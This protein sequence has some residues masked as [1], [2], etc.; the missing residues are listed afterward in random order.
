[1]R[2][3]SALLVFAL[4]AAAAAVIVGAALVKGRIA[5]VEVLAV[6]AVLRYSQR[7]T[8]ALEVYYLALTQEFD[9][10]AHVRVVYKSEDVVVGNARLLLSRQVLVKIGENVSLYTNVFH[11]KG[12]S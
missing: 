2:Y 9:R 3:S 7:I 8:E 6:K 1:M 11:I 5:R 4:S 12:C 10:I